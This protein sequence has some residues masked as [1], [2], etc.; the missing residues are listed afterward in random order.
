MK[1]STRSRVVK[2]HTVEVSV[3]RLVE[4]QNEEFQLLGGHLAVVRNVEESDA[5]VV[6]LGNWIE[7]LG[8]GPEAKLAN[9]SEVNLELNPVRTLE[10]QASEVLTEAKAHAQAILAQAQAEAEQLRANAQTEVTEQMQKL[11]EEVSAQAYTEGFEKGFNQ[12]LIEGRAQAEHEAERRRKEAKAL[13]E[14]AERAVQEEFSK[15]DQELLHLVIKIAERVLRASL[16]ISPDLLLHQVR[17]L[18]LFPQEREGTSL[19]VSPED[20]AWLMA[21]DTQDQLQVALV[22]DDT[23]HPGDSFIECS[24]GIFDARLDAQLARLEHLLREELRHAGLE[25]A[26]R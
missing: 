11:R 18:A 19:H 25:Q 12:G 24:E 16:E 3:P 14:L 6:R 26:G 22:S 17:A 15:V 9:S 10:V 23:L 5:G 4:C 7:P 21:S 2:S 8:S 1:L 20:F 13:V